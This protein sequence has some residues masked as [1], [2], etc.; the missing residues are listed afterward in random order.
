MVPS[1]DEY[2]GCTDWYFLNALLKYIA[3]RDVGYVCMDTRGDGRPHPEFPG[4]QLARGQGA[5][6]FRSAAGT[7]AGIQRYMEVAD[8]DLQGLIHR[9]SRLGLEFPALA[10]EVRLF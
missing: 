7:V 1:I 4:L 8:P 5:L 9:A 10:S 2:L 3:W 6:S